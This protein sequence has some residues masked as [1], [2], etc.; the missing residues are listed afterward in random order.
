MMPEVGDIGIVY[1]PEAK[2]GFRLGLL[3]DFG[4]PTETDEPHLDDIVHIDTDTEGGILAGSNPRS[5]L[6]AVY[7]LLKLNGCRFLFPGIDGEHIPM[8][9]IQ[10]QKYHK[11]ADHQMRGHSIEGDPSLENVLDYIDYHAKCELN[12]FGCYGIFYY[13]RRYY[14]H[15]NNEANRP[16][17][18]AWRILLRHT[19][20]CDRLAE[21][22]IEKCQGND[23][24]AI[25]MLNAFM[26]E[27]GKYDYELER[28]LDYGMLTNAIKKTLNKIVTKI[29]L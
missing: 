29:E 2:D 28:Y 13:M 24:T 3:E 5:V 27:F 9:K 1:D 19:E 23:E 10:P 6:F 15:R 17:T 14:N 26:P 25:E 18:I 22:L 20:Y 12:C 16:Q 4:L 7:R 8:K 21:I 11:M